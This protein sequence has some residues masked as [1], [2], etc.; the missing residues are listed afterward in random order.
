MKIANDQGKLAAEESRVCAG[1]QLSETCKRN[2]E[3]VDHGD[4]PQ[5]IS[6][7]NKKRSSGGDT[8]AYLREE[9]K[10]DLPLCQEE[11]NLQKQ[12]L[13]IA[14]SK[15]GASEKQ[16]KNRR[17][18]KRVLT[19]RCAMSKRPWPYYLRYTYKLYTCNFTNH[20][21]LCRYFSRILTANF[22]RK[23]FE[24]ALFFVLKKYIC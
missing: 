24:K 15:E 1:E 5:K 4:Q 19:L 11:I 7:D 21:L 3:K 8:I 13:D 16:M 10:K 17:R 2:L 20:E 23:V 14:K 9:T 22:T 6:S 12:D 18:S